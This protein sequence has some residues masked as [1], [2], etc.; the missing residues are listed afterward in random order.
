MEQQW[1]DY[2]AR[3]SVTFY[4]KSIFVYANF[5]VIVDKLCSL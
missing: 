3:S 1:L 4:R 5:T 2:D